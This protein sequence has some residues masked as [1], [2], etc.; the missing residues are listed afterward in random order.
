MSA[1]FFVIGLAVLVGGAVLY[2]VLPP[3]L[4]AA[5]GVKKSNN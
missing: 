3:R 1:L 4:A 5:A 2:A